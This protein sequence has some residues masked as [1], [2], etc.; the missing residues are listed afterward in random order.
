M[1]LF[2]ELLYSKTKMMHFLMTLMSL[3]SLRFEMIESEFSTFPRRNSSK[4]FGYRVFS[5]SHWWNIFRKWGKHV[6]VRV[7]NVQLK[8][9]FVTSASH[10]S[11]GGPLTWWGCKV[12]Q[13]NEKCNNHEH[14]QNIHKHALLK[15]PEQWWKKVWI[16]QVSKTLSTTWWRCSRR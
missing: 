11:C 6:F 14:H 12:A 10:M 4:L 7:L 3:L 9:K 5:S 15:K 8:L 1:W 2:M 13:W 16:F